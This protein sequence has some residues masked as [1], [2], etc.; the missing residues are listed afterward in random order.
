MSQYSSS[1]QETLDYILLCKDK[2]RSSYLYDNFY[3]PPSSPLKSESKQHIISI[4]DSSNGSRMKICAWTFSLIDHFKLSRQTAVISMD[5]FDRFMAT[6]GNQCTA[7]LALLTAMT[8]VFI[9][10]KIHERTRIK[11]EDLALLSRGQ[12]S[13]FDIEEMEIEICSYISWLVH[14]PTAETFISL[15]VRFLPDDIDTNTREMIFENARYLA[16]LSV[17]DQYYIEHHAST[18][19]FATILHAIDEEVQLG[20]MP[21]SS[22]KSFLFVLDE[23][24]QFSI[25]SKDLKNVEE[26]LHQTISKTEDE[27]DERDQKR[28]N[29]NSSPI[30][31]IFV[32]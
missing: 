31:A 32:F 30:S 13:A 27:E 20:H 6:H 15:L 2:E 1:M 18:I 4:R 23:Y 29:N 10:V 9:A 24:A 12:F 11:S 28:A 5:I 19:A 8:S 26:R 14:P 16:E 21:A 3:S 25:H 17:F 7:E 22:L